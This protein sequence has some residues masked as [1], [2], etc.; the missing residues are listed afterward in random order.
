MPK[1]IATGKSGPIKQP[2]EIRYDPVRGVEVVER[3]ESVGDG[4]NGVAGNLAL[5]GASYRQ[6]KGKLKSELEATYAAGTASSSGVPEIT[7]DVWEI[8]AN[9]IQKDIREHPLASVT[10]IS[11]DV[12]NQIQ[13]GLDNRTKPADMSPALTGNAAKV[14]DLLRRG[15]THFSLG[16]Y[17]L[18]HTTTVGARTTR[19]VSDN[20]VECIY[21]TAQ[22]IA[23]ATNTGL[24]AY[25]LPARLST[26]IQAIQAPAAKPDYLWGW[27]KLPSTETTAA[28]NKV[29]ITTEYWLEQWS[30]FVY[31]LAT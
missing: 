31:G 7:T 2:S 11:E 5:A 18:R 27:R 29:E 3:W 24:W 9:E 21:T 22:L 26:K 14:Y 20:N 28:G 4:L 25:P 8:R 10:Y 6:T 16:Q 30:T 1:I 23:E 19:N 15:S 13:S 12:W 17:V